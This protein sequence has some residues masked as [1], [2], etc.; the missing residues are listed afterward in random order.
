MVDIS[1]LLPGIRK[2]RWNK[3]YDSIV[4]STSRSFELIIAGPYSL[5]FELQ[6]KKNVKYVKD[7][8]NPVRA[9]QIASQFAEGKYITWTADDGTYLPNVLDKVLDKMSQEDDIKNVVINGYYEGGNKLRQEELRLNVAY[10][11]SAFIPRDWYI[12]NVATM[13]TQFFYEL[14]GYDCLFQTTALSHADLAARAQRAGAKVSVMNEPMLECTHM[15]GTT[16]DHAPVHYAHI[17]HDEPYYKK[18]YNSSS[19]MERTN[20]DLQNWKEAPKVWNLSL[21]HI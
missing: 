18:I 7:Y 1:I 6:D 14:G 13:H 5:P 20:L 3:V 10:P 17:E 21:I 16:G 11:S 9:T 19:C 2:E 4:E 15:P 12:F 8:G